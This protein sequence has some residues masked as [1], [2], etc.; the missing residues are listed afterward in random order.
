MKLCKV[1]KK[2][3]AEGSYCEA[4]KG[5]EAQAHAQALSHLATNYPGRREGL[6][7]SGAWRRLSRDILNSRSICEVCGKVPSTTVHH[8]SYGDPLDPAALLAVC[9]TC[10]KGFYGAK[11]KGK[12]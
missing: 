11:R 4:H 10:H 9:E 5:I 7:K 1:C 8:Q 12:A 6:Y 2:I 3:I